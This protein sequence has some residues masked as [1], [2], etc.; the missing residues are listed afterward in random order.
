MTSSE[1]PQRRLSSKLGHGVLVLQD[2]ACKCRTA[3]CNVVLIRKSD[4]HLRQ[5]FGHSPH[6]KRKKRKGERNP[7]PFFSTSRKFYTRK[8]TKLPPDHQNRCFFVAYVFIFVG[9]MFME[10]LFVCRDDMEVL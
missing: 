3:S 7:I 5:E 4:W 6:S 1:P 8:I 10:L 2:M 9:V